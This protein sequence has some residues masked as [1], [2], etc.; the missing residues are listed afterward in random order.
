Y[1]ETGRSLDALRQYELVLKQEPQHLNALNNLGL[2]YSN[3]GERERAI[4]LFNRVIGLEPG[5]VKAHINLGNAFLNGKQWAEAEASYKMAIALDDKD[6]SP[7]INL[8]VVQ[9]EQGNFD[10]ARQQWESILKS[11]PDN[12]RVL[13][14]MASGYLEKK[15]FDEAI[16]IFKRMV[17]L[18][19]NNGGMANTLGYLLA[20][21]NKELAFAKE[22][23]ER[24]LE[25]DPPNRAAYLDSLAWVLYRKGQFEKARDL[26]ERALKIFR[27]IHEPITS[28]V[29]LHMGKI[30][31]RLK[32]NNEAREAFEEALKANSD[33]DAVRD[34]E[35]GLARLTPKS[36][37]ETGKIE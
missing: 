6:L 20:E 35:E 24:A 21:Q 29:Y 34:A 15:K 12:L 26:Q 14:V 7:K 10:Q 3:I 13:S 8:G 18:M 4:D 1:H 31:E 9:F 22:L 2:V 25:L 19:P 23:I 16:S 28:E 30:Y 5:N 33:P 37:G 27:L 32:K 11:D 17:K 36:T